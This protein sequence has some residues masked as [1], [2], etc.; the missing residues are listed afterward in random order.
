MIMF[1]ISSRAATI[2]SDSSQHRRKSL[3]S[4]F[5]QS[6]AVV[7]LLRLRA[8]LAPVIA[9]R[10]MLSEIFARSRVA[11]REAGKTNRRG[12]DKAHKLRAVGWDGQHQKNPAIRQTLRNTRRT[13]RL[14][15][16]LYGH[17]AFD[18]L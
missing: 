6:E 18:T 10:R 13:L 1:G 15:G 8:M 2:L 3:C 11:G 5:S 17:S 12:Q 9:L 7:A 14:S 4:D 16:T